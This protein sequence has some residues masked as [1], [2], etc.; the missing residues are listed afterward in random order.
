M[1]SDPGFASGCPQRPEERSKDSLQEGVGGFLHG[2]GIRTFLV[3]VGFSGIAEYFG[4]GL[5]SFS[6]FR[7]GQHVSAYVNG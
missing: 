7:R 2:H 3:R 1:L 5:E 6:N 4:D